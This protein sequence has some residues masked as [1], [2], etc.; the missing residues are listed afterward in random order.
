MADGVQMS[1][2]DLDG[3]GVFQALPE[4]ALVFDVHGQVI[5]GNPLAAE[6]FEVEY[7]FPQISVT[8]LLGQPERARL[9]PVAW[10]RK[11]ADTPDAPELDYVYLTCKTASGRAKQLSVRVAR[12]GNDADT[13]YLVTMHDVTSW[14]ERLREEREAHRV[15]A[16]VLAISADAVVVVEEDGEITY[17]NTSADELFGYAGGLRGMKLDQLLP[18]RFHTQHH[19]FMQRFAEDTSP[20]RLMGQ[21][22]PVTALTASGEEVPVEAAITRITSGSRR[23]YSAQL[24]DLRQR[25]A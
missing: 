25:R 5:A 1:W 21:R 12:L 4:P 6:L 23:V 22:A 18:E 24:R 14:E 9:D 10:M 7:P 8:E 13:C 15:A 16:R 19:Q 3:A 11:W 17:A 2:S 20:A